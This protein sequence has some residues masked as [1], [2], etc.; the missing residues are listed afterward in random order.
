MKVNKYEMERLCGTWKREGVCPRCGGDLEPSNPFPYGGRTALSR[1]AKI[2]ICPSCGTAEAMADFENAERIR[3]NFDAYVA[4]ELGKWEIM[5][6]VLSKMDTREARAAFISAID[7]NVFTGEN[8]D[9]EEVI[10]GVVKD[11]MIV[12]TR[13]KEKP[14][15]YECVSYDKDGRQEGVTYI[16]AEM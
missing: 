11:G 15:W 8:T 6:D 14:Q 12:K 1:L 16:P 2:S 9:G 10:V 13:H 3:N 4:E 5:K 7:G